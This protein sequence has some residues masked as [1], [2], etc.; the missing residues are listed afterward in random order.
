MDTTTERKLASSAYQWLR[1]SPVATITTLLIVFNLDIGSLIFQGD[2]FQYS[3][4]S[5]YVNLL[6]GVTISA[7]WH[8]NLLRFAN[9]DESEFVR[10]HGKLA[11]KR[12]AIRTAIPLFTLVLDFAMG[13]SGIM[14]CVAISVLI[15]LWAGDTKNGLLEIEKALGKEDQASILHDTNTPIGKSTALNPED[16]NMADD[17]NPTPEETLNTILADLQSNDETL[18]L[19]TITELHQIKFSSVA[20]RKQLEK[21]VTQGKTDKLRNAALDALNIPS[22]RNVASHSNKIEKSQRTV[23][24]NEIRNWKQDGLIEETKAELISRRYDFDIAKSTASP[25]QTPPRH[26]PAQVETKAAETVSAT[27]EE[28]AETPSPAKSMQPRPSLL[29]TLTSETSIKIYLYLGAFFV[30]ASAVI[31]GLAVPELRLP[32]LIIATLIFGGLAV[33][34]KKRLPQPSFALFIIF[35]FLLPITANSILDAL[36]YKTDISFQFSAGYWAVVYFMMA[37]VWSGSTWLYESRLFSITAFIALCLSS[38]RLGDL[39]DAKPEFYTI[40]GGLTSLVGLGGS[41]ALKRWKDNKFA[42]PLFVT[43]QLTQG[44]ILLVSIIL[45]SSTVFDPSSQ[46]LWHLGALLTWALAFAFFVFSERLWPFVLF[47]WLAG[48]TLIPMPWFIGAAF[49]LESLASTILLLGWG[50]ITSITSEIIHRFESRRKYSLPFLL[51]SLPAFGLSIVTAFAEGNTLAAITAFAIALIYTVLHIIRT[52][53]WLWTIALT[54]FVISYAAFLNIEAVKNLKIFFGYELLFINLLFLLPDLFLKNDFK[55]N[56]SL[57]LPPRVFGAIFTGI[58]FFSLLLG[59]EKPHVNTA[60]IFLA[61]AVFFVIYAIRY[62][63][64]WI[65]Y[66][67]TSA[68]TFFVMYMFDLNKYWLPILTALSILYFSI[69]I[70]IRNAK[71]WTYILRNSSLILGTILSLAALFNQETTGYWCPILIGLIFVAEMYLRRNG[72]FEIGMPAMFTIGAY[73]ILL[74]FNIQEPAYH[75]LAYSIVWLSTDLLAHLTFANPR[76][77]KWAVRVIGIALSTINLFVLFNAG[78]NVDTKIAVIGYGMYAALSLTFSLVYKQPNI[79]YAFTSTFAL[80]IGF[81]FHWLGVDKWIHPVIAVAIMYYIIG[82]IFRS[83]NRAQGWEHPLIY[84]GLGLGIVTSIAS[85]TVGNLDAAL[86]AALAATL[87]AIEA[88]VKKNAWLALP[89]NGLY[90]FAYFIIL[91]KL[92]VNEPQFFSIGTALLGLIQHYLLVRSGSKTGAFIMGLLSQFVLLGTTYIELIGKDNLWYFFALFIQ[93][94]IVLIY[95]IAIRSRSLTFSPIGFVILGVIT[96]IYSALKNEATILLIGCTGIILLLL[97][98]TAVLLRE[99]ITKLSER[100]NDWN[101]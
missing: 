33:A 20:I 59:G 32:I 28:R 85:P 45:F 42:L 83:T 11:L 51:A 29:Q 8:L 48:A 13:T 35:S 77:L 44:L 36:Q 92:D 78:S 67:S 14:S 75:I 34:I 66:I 97:G 57:R 46:P 90:L 58:N 82:F 86:P 79:S 2:G 27:P 65:G 52:R 63:Q 47:P 72:F 71:D 68:L 41:Y 49:D 1:V 87:W 70:L 50:A 74:Q 23:I 73:L 98:I 40:M 95:G 4:N 91:V 96:I 62:N 10:T 56:P 53:W 69:G 39:L 60:I 89:A 15:I 17:Q 7:L 76:P 24:L 31:L 81:L 6:L 99:R 18:I 30:I 16:E 21:L 84:S 25:A 26:I 93:S 54:S 100:L 12:A 43:T 38:I 64:A 3:N 80:F 55:D 9:N 61:Y 88:F 5:V 101:A 19:E 22:L 94:I 37:L